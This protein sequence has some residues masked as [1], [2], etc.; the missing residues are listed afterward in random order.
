M[1]EDA[2]NIAMTQTAAKERLLIIVIGTDICQP[3]PNLSQIKIRKA[4]FTLA[5]EFREVAGDEWPTSR[6]QTS[7]FQAA[8]MTILGANWNVQHLIRHQGIGPHP[9]SD[10]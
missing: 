3:F 4:N 1:A 9:L 10:E 2:C 8:V 6:S 7:I 5:L